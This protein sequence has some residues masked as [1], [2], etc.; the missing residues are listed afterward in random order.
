MYM[1]LIMS[2]NQ[3]TMFYTYNDPDLCSTIHNSSIS[4]PRA[5]GSM[6]K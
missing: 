6:K 3:F 1:Y 4:R 2:M 5:T